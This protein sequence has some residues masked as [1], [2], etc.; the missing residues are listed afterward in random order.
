MLLTFF[1]DTALLLLIWLVQLIIYPV[2]AYMNEQEL[3]RW[4][5]V[6]V[7]RISGFV[8]P[9]M[10]AQFIV[11]LYYF[12]Y[13][14]PSFLRLI[15]LAII[16]INTFYLAIPLHATIFNIPSEAIPEAV[17][18][19]LRINWTRTILWTLLWFMSVLY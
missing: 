18:K 17:K 13:D 12:D 19:L 9:L 2:F 4:H 14:I 5:S 6:Y 3:R 8:A 11:S 16:W 1:I 7:K 15:F 10:L